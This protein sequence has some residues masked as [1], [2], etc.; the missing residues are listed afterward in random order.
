VDLLVQH[1]T[2]FG[3]DFQWWLP[4]V[5]GACALYGLWLWATDQ[6]SDWRR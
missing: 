1:F 4:I 2:L 5:G 6:F 3:I